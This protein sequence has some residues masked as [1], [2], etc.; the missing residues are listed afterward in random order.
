MRIGDLDLT[1]P[2]E[3]DLPFFVRRD[4]TYDHYAMDVVRTLT[5]GSVAPAVIDVGANVGDTAI[6]MLA[7]RP[8]LRVLSVEGSPRFAEYLQRNLAPHTDRATWRIGFVGSV[9]SQAH[10]RQQGSTG[11]FQGDG[12]EVDDWISPAE[13]LAEAPPHDYLI[14]KSDIDGFDIHVLVQ[15][16]GD[17]DG[18]CDAIWFEYDPS[19]TLGD[20]S[21][22]D[23]LIQLLAAS[24]RRLLVHDNLGKLMFEL[25]CAAAPTVLPGLNDWLSVQFSSH[26]VVPYLDIW[27]V[28][29][30]NRESA[31]DDTRA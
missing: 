19:R 11:G 28:R 2:P 3:H 8:D 6:T 7:T 21:D 27:A 22:I 15:H 16:W 4:P 18:G 10:Y 25:P 24:G 30:P 14:W 13:L 9:G 5:R 26:L 29:E 20:R 31:A 23:R 12:V 17:I 1:L